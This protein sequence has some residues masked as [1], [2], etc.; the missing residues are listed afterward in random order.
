MALMVDFIWQALRESEL[1][2]VWAVSNIA[3]LLSVIYSIILLY[4]W[5][6]YPH[7]YE[8]TVQIQIIIVLR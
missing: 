2:N 7:K 4:R 3:F 8:Q 5:I 6:I 1:L